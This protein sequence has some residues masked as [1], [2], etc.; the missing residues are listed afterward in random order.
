MIL[1][2]LYDVYVI[3][4]IQDKRNAGEMKLSFFFHNV[5]T[6]SAEQKKVG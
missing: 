6:P 4:F 2:N 5:D 1:G 3:I